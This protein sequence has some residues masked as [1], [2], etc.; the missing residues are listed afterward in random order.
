[1]HSH[2]PCTSICSVEPIR[3]VTEEHSPDKELSFFFASVTRATCHT[4]LCPLVQ[5]DRRVSLLLQDMF[6][7]SSC[8]EALFIINAIC[9]FFSL[10][11]L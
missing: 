10:P 6:G 4:I 9:F 2:V 3:G 7:S 11:L 8:H 1:M 5:K